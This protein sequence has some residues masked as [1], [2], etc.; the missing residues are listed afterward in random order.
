M[1][2][3]I[4]VTVELTAREVDLVARLH[5][6]A[7]EAVAFY[8]ASFSLDMLVALRHEAREYMPA[9]VLASMKAMGA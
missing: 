3:G 6:D 7:W 1:N 4:V 8:P 2:D 5:F 9:Y